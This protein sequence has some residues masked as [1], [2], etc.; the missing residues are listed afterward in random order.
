MRIGSSLAGAL[1]TV[2]AAFALAVAGAA[3]AVAA[4]WH[5]VTPAGGDNSDEVAMLRTADGALHL[6]WV[7]DNAADPTLQDIAS[8]TLAAGGKSLGPVALVASGW[9]TLSNPAL[10][11][12]PA[13]LRAF[14]GGIHTLVSGD[15]NDEL[16][17]AVSSDGGVSW[18]LQ[19]GNVSDAPGA[20]ASDTAATLPPSGVPVIAG[21]GTG[22]DVYVTTGLVPAP[23][24]APQSQ[25][26][27]AFGDSPNLATD[28]SG[29]PYLA[30]ASQAPGNRGIWAQPLTAAG[31]PAG[32][33]LRMP[34]LVE[35]DAF[36]P[37]SQ[38]TPLAARAGGGVYI[39]YPAGYP[40]TTRVKLWK[41]GAP[42]SRTIAQG[43]G[44]HVATVAAAAAGRLWVLWS[45]DDDR[46]H[47]ARTNQAATRLGAW[48]SAAPPPGT[49][50]I[51]RLDASAAS[52]SVDVL[53]LTDAG[54]DA[55]WQRRLLPGLTLRA[56]PAR[57]A[58]GATVQLKARVLDAGVPV[59]G[60]KVSV[61]GHA[62]KTDKAG[63]ATLAVPVGAHASHLLVT[64]R[65]GGYTA[66]RLRLRAKR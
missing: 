16:S 37:E 51:Y 66:A 39:A 50:S 53:A 34:G 3:P 12:G 10:V 45:G 14:F 52:G 1:S 9:P 5:R 31:G 32:P 7:Q 17:T 30:W 11:P 60:A 41:V 55:T 23:I 58:A 27:A 40:A 56:K 38:R 48:V 15:P 61:G 54:A 13:G 33:P 24:F 21:G 62:A 26:G 25:L 18:A 20:Y 43:P 36:A 46:I 57:P 28:A 59:A 29:T 6:A 35:K 42:R 65:R 2:L 47:V 63:R 4:S 44:D 19:V 8:R 22:F 49:Q 64:A